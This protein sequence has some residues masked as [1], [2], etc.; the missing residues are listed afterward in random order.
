VATLLVVFMADEAKFVC[1]DKNILTTGHAAN[2]RGSKRKAKQVGA[3][4][5]KVKQAGFRLF[6]G[7]PNLVLMATNYLFGPKGAAKKSP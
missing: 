1:H 4:H 6:F 7:W 5:P 3:L 2:N